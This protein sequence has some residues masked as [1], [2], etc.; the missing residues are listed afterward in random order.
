MLNTVFQ[1]FFYLA[2]WLIPTAL[3]TIIGAWLFEYTRIGDILIEILRRLSG[4]E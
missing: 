3:F 2:P 1:T 4:G